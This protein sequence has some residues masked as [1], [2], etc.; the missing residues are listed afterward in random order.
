[1]VWS[2]IHITSSHRVLFSP[3]LIH[4]MMPP[5]V[6]STTHTGWNNNHR[7]GIR[8]RLKHTA[9][10]APSTPILSSDNLLSLSLLSSHDIHPLQGPT[11]FQ[12]LSSSSLH[13]SS[14]KNILHLGE[15]KRGIDRAYFEQD[16][17][18][19]I[20]N[21]LSSNTIELVPRSSIPAN[22]PPLQ[23]IW[24]FRQK[25]APDWSMIKRKARLCPH[26]GL[27]KEGINFWK[28]YAPVVSWRTVHLTLVLSLLSGL[29]SR[30]VD[31]VLA[32]TQAP[33]DCELFTNIPPG[34]AVINNSIKFSTSTTRSQSYGHV[35]NINKNVYG[36]CQAGNNWFTKLCGSLLAMKFRQSV[37]DPCLFIRSDCIIVVDDCLIFAKEDS[38]LDSVID[39]LHSNFNLTS[40]GRVG[41]FLGI[42]IKRTPDNNLELVQPGLISIISYVGLENESNEHKAPATTILHPDESCL[43]REHSWNYC[44]VIGMLTYLSTSTRPDIA[45]AVHQC[46][47]FSCNPK[48]SH[49][50]AVHHIIHYLKGTRNKGFILH[51]SSSRN[52][53]CYVDANFAGLWSSDLAHDPISVKSRTGYVITFGN[54]PI[55]WSY[56]LQTE[57]ILS[58]T[59]AEYIALS[60]SAWDLIPMHDLLLEFSSTT[61]L[62]VGNTIMHSTI[63]EDNKW[64]VEL[65]NAPKLRPR[66]KHIGLKYH[67]FHSHVSNGHI[68][69]QWIDSKHQLA[70]IFTEPLP[71]STF[72]YLHSLLLGW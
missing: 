36:L 31:Y 21:L 33:L 72:E 39:N 1:M 50:I 30:Q 4:L 43:E 3:S 57:I 48:R 40:Q 47:R 12:S 44:K 23:A 56:K 64:C 45:F 41:V 25:R 38:T 32:Y 18:H 16:M 20:N 66:T 5:P 13:A 9:N 17:R 46:A 71:C 68:C 59:E 7:Y 69:I 70:D 19:E 29:K 49:E 51:P 2:F 55:M 42:N 62:I 65:A 61:K 8:F 14:T 22:N 15:M 60:Q 54:C 27:Q 28:T 67:H 11:C 34:Y 58:T 10:L 35:L 24:S 53:D 26:G 52:L 6:S 63:F 37:N